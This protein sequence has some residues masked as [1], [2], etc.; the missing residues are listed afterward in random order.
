MTGAAGFIGSTLCERLLTGGFQVIGLDS[1]DS[2]YSPHRK[3]QNLERCLQHP[4][5]HFVKTDLLQA[6]FTGLLSGVS[7]VFHLAARPG[8]RTEV[9]N[10]SVYWQ[11]NIQ[12]TLSLLEAVKEY[13]LKKF[14]L[15]STSSVYGQASRFPL[16]EAAEACPDSYYGISKLAAEK[17]CFL[18]N[19][20][21]QVPMVILRYFSVY[22]PRQRPDMAF[23]RFI[24]AL[25]TDESLT[26]Y[27]DGEQTRDFTFITDIVEGSLRAMI[28][29]TA[30]GEIINLGGG[31]RISLKETIALMES[32][33]SRK[34]KVSFAQ[35][36]NCEARHTM[37]DIS[38]A[39][40]LLDYAPQ[41][42]IAEGIA[43]Q[44][45]YIRAN[46]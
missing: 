44:I 43:R 29:S 40:R 5:F 32:L 9:G 28:G 37:A 27:G 7:Y 25:L 11:Q 13:P 36:I 20:H 15:A 26:V 17:L 45:E 16:N 23:D 34:A 21:Y 10:A 39:R 1:L 41:T 6:D 8:V 38:K 35:S 33:T 31:H 24:R 4:A 3:A 18:Y 19:T 14:I 42:A 22:G 2:Y 46:R 30:G 12:G